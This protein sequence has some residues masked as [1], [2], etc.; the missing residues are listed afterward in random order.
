MK[1]L[2]KI[3]IIAEIGWNH[4]GSINL[5]EKMIKTAAQNGADYC[6]FQTWSVGNL[7]QG[8]WDTDG[9]R[10]IYEKAQLNEASHKKLKK[11]CK[12]YNVK[13]FT[14]VFNIKDVSMLKKINKSIIKIPSH[15]IYNLELI[16]KC[17][18][19]FNKI[20]ISTGAAKWREITNIAKLRNFKKKAILLHCVSSYPCNIKNINLPRL[21]SLKKLT[22]SVGYSGHYEGIEDAIAAICKGCSYIEKHFTTN[23]SLP[24]RDNKFAILPS[25]L[26]KISKF[27]DVFTHMSINKGLDLQNCEMSIY[28]DYRGRWSHEVN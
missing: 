25:D 26:N 8:P 23:K 16:Q 13:F 24:G 9:R 27:R 7:R 14:S 4:M 22:T 11:I 19:S 2:S 12:H 20:L 1:N 6:K 18:N 28:K 3:N 5:A 10:E 15:E 17:L 21:E